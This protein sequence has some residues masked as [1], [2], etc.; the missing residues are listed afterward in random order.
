[1]IPV[2]KR[3]AS[4]W[5]SLLK[6]YISWKLW[7]AR[8]LNFCP[9][10]P[11]IDSK[12]TQSTFEVDYIW[13]ILIDRTPHDTKHTHVDGWFSWIRRVNEYPTMHYFGIPRNTQSMI[14][15]KILTECFWKFQWKIALWECCEHAPLIITFLQTEP[16]SSW[17][18]S[19]GKSS[20]CSPGSRYSKFEAGPA[21]LSTSLCLLRELS[22]EMRQTEIM[23][24]VQI[25]HLTMYLITLP[26][27]CQIIGHRGDSHSTCH[28]CLFYFLCLPIEQ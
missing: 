20:E 16:C 12:T 13:Y 22:V 5:A 1:M 23:A 19:R 2:G 3:R 15:Y 4:A 11:T 10:S 7:R 24:T 26:T 27:S 18:Q 6:S 21:G 14:A 17:R 8:L 9:F 28:C 25:P